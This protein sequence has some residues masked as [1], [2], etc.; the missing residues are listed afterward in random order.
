MKRSPH[1]KPFTHDLRG[2]CTALSK[3]WLSRFELF[4]AMRRPNSYLST[5]YLL[6]LA[7]KSDYVEELTP[8]AAWGDNTRYYKLTAAGRNYLL[9][10]PSDCSDQQTVIP[11]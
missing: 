4:R 5:E 6:I 8:N 2:L 1:K 10:P 9:A 7:L 3:G 11:F